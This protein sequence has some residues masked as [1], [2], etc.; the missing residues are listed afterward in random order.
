L[1]GSPYAAV[2]AVTGVSRL[3][4]TL[5]TGDITSKVGAA[6]HA[7][8]ASRRGGSRFSP[9]AS[10]CAGAEPGRSLCRT[11]LERRRDVLAVIDLVIDAGH[12]LYA[13]QAH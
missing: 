4:Y 13:A 5:A 9:K 7:L 3:R 1:A 6:L 2:W 11:P 10:G 12:R 8:H